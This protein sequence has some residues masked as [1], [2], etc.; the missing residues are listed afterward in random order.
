MP[1]RCVILLSK[2]SSNWVAKMSGHMTWWCSVVDKA[3]RLQYNTVCIGYTQLLPPLK[4][5]YPCHLKIQRKHLSPKHFVSRWNCTILTLPSLLSNFCQKNWAVFSIKIMTKF[6][7][8]RTLT[9]TINLFTYWRVKFCKK[10]F[11]S[12]ALKK[13]ENSF[14]KSKQIRS[15]KIIIYKQWG[16]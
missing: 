5:Q 2:W 10:K 14:W 6:L 7:F 3:M 1:E 15:P 12:H 16:F 8:W 9:F 4:H 13:I 11:T